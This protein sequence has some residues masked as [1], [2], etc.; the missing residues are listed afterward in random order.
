[1]PL[2]R[3]HSQ[4]RKKSTLKATIE[5][6]NRAEL[7]F[8]SARRQQ[9]N[10]TY[11]ESESLEGFNMREPQEGAWGET[12][13]TGIESNAISQTPASINSF[14]DIPVVDIED[15]EQQLRAQIGLPPRTIHSNSSIGHTNILNSVPVMTTSNLTPNAPTYFPIPRYQHVSG[16]PGN[17]QPFASLPPLNGNNDSNTDLL[18]KALILKLDNGFSGLN[19]SL[20]TQ[21]PP[22]PPIQPPEMTYLTRAL[23]NLNLQVQTLTERLS[24]DQLNFAQNADLGANSSRSPGNSNVNRSEPNGR[25]ARSQSYSSQSRHHYGNLPRDWKLRYDGD[26]NKL[27]V[28][29]FCDQIEIL[30]EANGTDWRDVIAALPF[31]LEG[32]AA[33]WFYRFIKGNNSTEWNLLKEAMIEY[34]RGAESTESLYCALA[35]RK[36]GDREKFDDFYH[37]VLN[38]LDRIADG[39]PDTQLIGI[40]RENVKFDIQKCLVTYCPTSLS[41]FVNK[42]R[43]TDKLLREKNCYYLRKVSEVQMEETGKDESVRSM[44]IEA[45]T[46]RRSHNSQNFANTKCWNC[47]V[48]GHSWQVCDEP[49]K[50]FCYWCGFKN[51]RCKTC[52]SCNS[53]NFRFGFQQKEP[54]PPSAPPA[55]H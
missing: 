53:S 8:S 10:L 32:E 35:K 39:V 14:G 26:N 9:E 47:D 50:I 54:P 21:P 3:S 24:G 38:I 30:Q 51:V 34:F 52:P 1:M 43:L 16:M 12:P 41:D 5:K 25:N 22:P 2:T 7:S 44:D 40:L 15:Q 49:L 36:Q 37:S 31:F 18:L 33:K 11:S 29:F 48:L 23:S 4:K 46:S 20:R 19:A 45:L 28:E 13:V 6:V 27:A 17:S 55:N 42:C